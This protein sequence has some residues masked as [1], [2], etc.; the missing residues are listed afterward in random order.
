MPKLLNKTNLPNYASAPSSPAN[1]DIYYN[2]TDH[3]VY[4][5]VNG[6]WVD[7]GAGGGSG[8]I[9]EVVA[10]A[11]LTGGAISGSATIDVGA[12]TGIT[13]NANDVAIDTTVVARKTDK[14][15]AFAATTSSELAGVISDETGSNKLVFSDG[16]T[17]VTPTLGVASATSVNK[18]AITEPATSA[19][20]TIADGKTLT[21]NNTLTFTGTDAS[22]VAFGNGGTVLYSGGALGTPSSGTLTNAT[23]LPVSGITASTT[24]ALGVGSIELGHATDT[25]ITRV[26]AG[27]IS[28]EGNTVATLANNIGDFADSTTGAVGIGTIELGHATDTTLARGAAGIL[29]VEGVNVVTTSS[30]DTLTNKTISASN[31][32]I[33]GVAK[34]YYQA[35]A[36]S[37]PSDGDIWIDSDDEIGSAAFTITDSISTTSSTTA[38]SAT[39]VKKAYDLAGSLESN[40]MLMGG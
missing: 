11:G 28:V 38:A 39:A 35:S 5:R 4:A 3:I 37:S 13:V 18:V 16:P 32:T 23:G 36:P 31:N 14:L 27:L 40:L 25:T 8:D 29:T 10:G 19:T 9:T 6:A 1:G 33:S 34:V 22:S 7:L 12:G 24:S 17:L 15:S 2:T 26:S 20:L 30:T 21:A